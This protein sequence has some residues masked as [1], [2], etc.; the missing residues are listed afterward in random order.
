MSE[1]SRQFLENWI[2]RLERLKRNKFLSQIKDSRKS[3]SQS[4]QAIDK[5]PKDES[6]KRKKLYLIYKKI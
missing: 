1:R 6:K 4:T 5:K 3:Q 2:K